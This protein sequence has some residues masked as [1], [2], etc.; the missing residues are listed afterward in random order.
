ME[1]D[2][3]IWRSFS[4]TPLLGHRR[5]VFRQDLGARP[6]ATKVLII[7]TDGEAT[8]RANIDSAKDIIRYI[9]GV[10][11]LAASYISSFLSYSLSPTPLSPR[12]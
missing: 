9:I 2:F 8:D 11:V 4:H 6:D 1:G 3:I 5:E 12:G 7:I 10:W